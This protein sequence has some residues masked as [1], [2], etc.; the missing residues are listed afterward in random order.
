MNDT[1]ERQEDQTKRTGTGYLYR[2]RF[3]ARESACILCVWQRLKGRPRSGKVY[4]GRGIAR[5]G[6]SFAAVGVGKREAS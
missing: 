2:V 6:A 1:E 4:G 5:G 3:I